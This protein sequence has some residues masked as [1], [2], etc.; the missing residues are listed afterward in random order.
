MTKRTPQEQGRD[1]D[2][3]LAARYGGQGRSRELAARYGGRAQP[4][5][6]WPL[7]ASSIARSAGC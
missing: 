5:W 7:G 3:E 2:S 6:R 4:Q 1:Y